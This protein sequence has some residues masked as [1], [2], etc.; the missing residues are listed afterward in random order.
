MCGIAGA[1]AIGKAAPVDAEWLDAM[2]GALRH[3]GPDDS[4]T[5][6]ARDGRAGLAAARLMIT[7]SSPLGAQPMTDKTGRW[8]L[9]FNG[10]IYNGAALRAE[11]EQIGYR[12]ESRLSDTEVLLNALAAWQTDSLRRLRGMYAFALWDDRD[13]QLWLA[14]DPF[15]VKPLYWAEAGG[16]LIFASEPGALFATGLVTAAPSVQGVF[17]WLS[18]LAVPAPRSLYQGVF[19]LE[20]GTFLHIAY[21]GTVRRHRHWDPVVVCGS[22]GNVLPSEALDA[23]RD[24]LEEA[25]RRAMP[26]NIDYAVMLSGGVDSGL[27]AAAA[28][29]HGAGRPRFVTMSFKG[30]HAFDETDAAAETARHL[31]VRQEVITA[32][33]EDI[34]AATMALGEIRP[35]AP[36]ATPDMALTYLFA[37]RMARNGTRVCLQGEGADEIGGYPS[38]LAAM[39]AYPSLSR[40]NRLPHPIKSLALRLSPTAARRRFD[41]A[42][43]TN[44]F[45]ARHIQ[46]F[47]EVDKSELW[48]GGHVSSSFETGSALTDDIAG[49][50]ADTHFRRLIALEFRLRLPEFL[51]ARSDLATMAAGIEAR[52]PFLDLD[53]VTYSLGLPAQVRMRHNCAKWLF[54]SLFA[55]AVG[56]THAFREK[57]GYGRVLS[58]LLADLVPKLLCATLSGRH[59][60]ALYAFLRPR[61]VERLL[62]LDAKRRDPY[63]LWTLLALATWLDKLPS[64]A[65]NRGRMASQ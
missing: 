26:D 4:G 55:E 22:M 12:F 46:A 11:L 63:Q 3:R 60:H 6:R 23:T 28:R 59:D 52:Q 39:A 58:P 32:S 25:I 33:E 65:P 62:T 5:W 43:G 49:R 29:R 47:D 50:S 40:F 7:D 64:L 53:L 15:G 31:G 18:F 27:I 17:D 19:A 48:D 34:L 45:P 10:E 2:V 44:V 30:A 36:L 61:A 54:K 13:K 35:E 21:G 16:H 56:T 14:R 41:P 9:V 38:Y 57:R 8:H 20:A 24:H 51:L 42:F 1:V 37:R